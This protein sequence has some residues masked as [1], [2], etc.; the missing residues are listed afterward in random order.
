M[1]INLGAHVVYLNLLFP[2]SGIVSL[3]DLEKK[4]ELCN[5]TL[6]LLRFLFTDE[7]DTNLWDSHIGTG[8]ASGWLATTQNLSHSP[9]AGFI[10]Y[11]SEARILLHIW[12]YVFRD[13]YMILPFRVLS[14]DDVNRINNYTLIMKL[15]YRGVDSSNNPVVYFI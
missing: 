13:G 7:P 11:G 4:N 15:V 5:V 9:C 8:D 14:R 6:L 10:L 2:Y 1:K 12:D 3:C